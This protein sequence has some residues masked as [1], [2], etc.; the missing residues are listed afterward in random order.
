MQTQFQINQFAV[1]AVSLFVILP[2]LHSVI[3]VANTSMYLSVS[4]PPLHISYLCSCLGVV[5]LTVT[6]LFSV[7]ILGYDT[8]Q[9]GR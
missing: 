2:L 9:F 6:P 5:L 4:T 7:D 3:A 1:E 8:V